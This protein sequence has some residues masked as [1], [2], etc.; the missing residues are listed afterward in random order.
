MESSIINGN[1]LVL[2]GRL[3]GRADKDLEAALRPLI[4]VDTPHV[5][6]DFSGVTFIGAKGI[7]PL[8]A[9][10]QTARD[11]NGSFVLTNV[12]NQIRWDLEGMGFNGV[13]QIEQ[14]PTAT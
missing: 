3:D 9:A 1:T 8:L 6:V 7:Q 13:F 10:N 4:D 11:K 5:I 14:N 2:V 12:A